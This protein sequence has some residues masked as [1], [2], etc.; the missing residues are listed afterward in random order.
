MVRALGS[1]LFNG[2]ALALVLW[3]VVSGA[4]EQWIVSLGFLATNHAD[5]LGAPAGINFIGSILGGNIVIQLIIFLGFVAWALN[6]T[7]ASELQATRYMLA[8]S[9]VG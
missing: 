5:E 6:G 9:L 1:T 8:A 7:P 2:L 4:G 3:L